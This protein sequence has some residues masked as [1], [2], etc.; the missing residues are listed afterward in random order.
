M[1]DKHA[2]LQVL[3]DHSLA[4]QAAVTKEMELVKNLREQDAHNLQLVD[5]GVQ[6]EGLGLP[7]EEALPHEQQAVITKEH[8]LIRLQTAAQDARLRRAAASR[9]LEEATVDLE[10]CGAE[11]IAN[12]DAA[13][14]AEQQL[15]AE[16]AALQDH[17]NRIDNHKR[18][19]EEIE[20]L[21]STAPENL[22]DA[23]DASAIMASYKNANRALMAVS[24]HQTAAE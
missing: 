19:S 1:T 17:I 7:D 10:R 23:T 6:L 21:K 20:T 14:T 16:R 5:L 11:A 12:T 9:R 18:L 15:G 8:E 3:L 13:T 4:L 24:W 2:S 22:A